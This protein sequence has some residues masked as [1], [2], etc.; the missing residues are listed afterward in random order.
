MHTNRRYGAYSNNAMSWNV[1]VIAGGMQ[2]YDLK[3]LPVPSPVSDCRMPACR[4]IMPDIS[5]YRRRE[6]KCLL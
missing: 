6:L 4:C 2:M 1:V 3:G 5:A